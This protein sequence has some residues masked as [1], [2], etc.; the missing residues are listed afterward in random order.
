MKMMYLQIE[1]LVRAVK[2][3]LLW[4]LKG[5]REGTFTALG[6]QFIKIA[7]FLTI[8]YLPCDQ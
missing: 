3:K 4:L 2:L 5:S 1:E 6:C 7:R 8:L